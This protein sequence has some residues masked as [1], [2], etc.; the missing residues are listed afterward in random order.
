A[1]RAPS[2]SLTRTS[3][4]T[5]RLHTVR[6]IPQHNPSGSNLLLYFRFKTVGCETVPDVP[7]TPPLPG[8]D[9]FPFD[10]VLFK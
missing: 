7:S 3:H 2:A 1:L 6:H 8:G 10:R 5:D 9:P 4:R